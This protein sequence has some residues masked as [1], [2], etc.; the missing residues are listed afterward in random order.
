MFSFEYLCN[1][2]DICVF[3]QPLQAVLSLFMVFI[4]LIYGF[5]CRI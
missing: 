3:F 2:L 1:Y 5:F 4:G